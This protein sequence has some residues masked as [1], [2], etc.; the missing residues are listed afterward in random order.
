MPATTNSTSITI[1]V[2]E[3]DLAAAELRL[4]AAQV[5]EVLRT[6]IR[7]Q[8]LDTVRRVKTEMPVDTG[9]ARASW[10]T[11]AGVFQ[12]GDG[13]WDEEDGGLTITQG[14]TVE[15]VQ[16][17]NEGSSSQAPAGFIDTAAVDASEQLQRRIEDAIERLLT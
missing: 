2:R 10:G 6:E 12:A 4:G 11:L 14:T 15:Y 3:V 8:A 17:L 5:A 13:I 1:D 9:R 16:N 7:A